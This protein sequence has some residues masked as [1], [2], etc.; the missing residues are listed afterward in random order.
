MTAT[1]ALVI[2]AKL[3]FHKSIE[4]KM[5]LQF[6]KIL[7]GGGQSVSFAIIEHVSRKVRPELDQ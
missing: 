6:Q 3:L 7:Q 1:A 5:P 2:C 4:K